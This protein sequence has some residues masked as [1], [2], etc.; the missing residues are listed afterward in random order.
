LK[1]NPDCIRDI[2]FSVEELTNG[3]D[4]IH[5]SM[6]DFQSYG[7]IPRLHVY[8]VD[9]VWGHAEQCI[10]HGYLQGAKI[11]AD[12]YFI[13]LDLSPDGHRFLADVRD[14]ANWK[15]TLKLCAEKVGSISIP[16]LQST[17]AGVIVAKLQG[18]LGLS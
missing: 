6:Q 3:I 9:E 14:D 4:A 1:L 13:V 16:V 17:S 12:G 18:L 15:E 7:A 11:G 2:L 8:T 5:C 10:N